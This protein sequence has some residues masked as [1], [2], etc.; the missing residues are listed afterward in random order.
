M[1]PDK[2]FT[3]VRHDAARGRAMPLARSSARFCP[4]AR[5]PSCAPLRRGAFRSGEPGCA[6][7]CARWSTV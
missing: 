1:R 2:T 7:P 3:V 6:P 5:R 4:L